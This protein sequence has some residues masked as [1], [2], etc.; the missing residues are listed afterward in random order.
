LR[1]AREPARIGVAMQRHALA[2]LADVRWDRSLVTQYLGS[3]LSEP[4]ADVFQ[5]AFGAEVA[6][7]V[8]GRSEKRGLRL[9]R[10]TQWLYDDAAIYV[11]GE[12]SPWPVGDRSALMHLAN[13]RSLPAKQTATLSSGMIAF[14]HE[15]IAMDSSTSPEPE[16]SIEPRETVLDTIAAQTAA[17]DELIALARQRLQISTSISQAAGGNPPRAEKLAAFFAARQRRGSTSSS[18]S[19]VGSRRRVRASSPSSSCIRTPSPCIGRDPKRAAR[20]IPADRRWQALPA[21][22]PYRSSSRF[23][24]DRAAATG[25]AAGDA[26][27]ADLGDRRARVERDGPRDLT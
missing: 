27:R 8:R 14:L 2:T 9:D 24:R 12:A 10:R 6:G 22:L 11:N 17:I 1:F 3:V 21:S 13:T 19:C 23:V 5:P 25:K 18:M 16:R 20:W 26:L 4:K 7:G 15:V